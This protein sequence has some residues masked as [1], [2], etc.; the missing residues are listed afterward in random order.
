VCKHF[1][2]GWKEWL[3]T[4]IRFFETRNSYGRDPVSSNDEHHAHVSDFRVELSTAAEEQL[5][6][7][8][9]IGY[10]D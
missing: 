5:C 10:S 3:E 2:F 9:R 6:I 7:D 1:F 8:E 4:A